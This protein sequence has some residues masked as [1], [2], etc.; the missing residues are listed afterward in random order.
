MNSIV[1]IGGGSL[2]GGASLGTIHAKHRESDVFP[3]GGFVINSCVNSLS[4][5]PFG[6]PDHVVRASVTAEVDR[7]GSRLTE[8]RVNLPLGPVDLFVASG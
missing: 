6:S 4:F 7:Q 3:E 2:R 1:L 8:H 5:E